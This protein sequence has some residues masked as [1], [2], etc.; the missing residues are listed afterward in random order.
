MRVERE[1]E[2]GNRKVV[3]VELT[4]AEIRAWLESKSADS[5]DLVDSLLFEEAS[6]TDVVAMT[7]LKA[8][9]I[10]GFTPSALDQVIAVCKE[11]NARFFAMRAR[12]AEIGKRILARDKVSDPEA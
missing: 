3:I 4:V 6:L 10:D 7:D 5:P 11:V 1:I 8:A 12:L 2:V 9:D